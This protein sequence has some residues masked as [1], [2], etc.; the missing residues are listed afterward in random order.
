MRLPFVYVIETAPRPTPMRRVSLGPAVVTSWVL[1]NQLITT[2]SPRSRAVCD[3][4]GSSA[5]ESHKLDVGSLLAEDSNP[6]AANPNSADDL[7][8]YLLRTPNLREVA[9]RRIRDSA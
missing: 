7:R 6:Y 2:V 9:E 8:A 4:S 5:T 3:T 1:L